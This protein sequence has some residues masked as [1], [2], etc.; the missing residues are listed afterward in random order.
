ML[1][2]GGRLKLLAV[3]IIRL[4]VYFWRFFPVNS[5]SS[6][7]CDDLR[8]SQNTTQGEVDVIALLVAGRPRERGRAERMHHEASGTSAKLFDS[9]SHCALF[10]SLACPQE[11]PIHGHVNVNKIE[12]S[13][14]WMRAA[15]LREKKSEKLTR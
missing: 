12:Q 6:T 1:V 7:R 8:G 3:H 15:V 14:R 9:A 4:Y 10:I 13:N 11:L 5:S 2:G